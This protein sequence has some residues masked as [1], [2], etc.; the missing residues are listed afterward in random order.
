LEW[1][2]QEF[3]SRTGIHCHV[4]VPRD[5]LVLDNERATAIFRIFQESLTNVARH[6]QATRVEARLESA[7]DHLLLE[8]KDNGIGFDADEAKQGKSLGIV[9]MRERAL[10][11]DGEITIKR[12][13]VAGTTLT[14]RIPLSLP[15]PLEQN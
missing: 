12:R 4:D 15:I 1:Q 6:A 5:P 8:V 9:G 2:A 10:L 7:G 3:Q 14:L 11:L 13:L